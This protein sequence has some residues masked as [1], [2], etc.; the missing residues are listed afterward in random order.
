MKRFTSRAAVVALAL[1]G[2]AEAGRYVL[3]AQDSRPT[4]TVGTATAQ[5]TQRA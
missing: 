5:R 3:S 1:A 2:P 4:F